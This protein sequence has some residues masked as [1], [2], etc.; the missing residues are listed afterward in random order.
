M[1]TNGHLGNPE[2]KASVFADRTVNVIV[3]GK[4]ALASKDWP[5]QVRRRLPLDELCTCLLTRSPMLR[6]GS[7]N[8]SKDLDR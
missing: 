6:T 8:S 3:L 4:A 1:I 2:T 7:W 5:H